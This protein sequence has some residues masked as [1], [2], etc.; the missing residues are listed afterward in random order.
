MIIGILSGILFVSGNYVFELRNEKKAK[1]EIKVLKLALQ[2]YKIKAE[3]FQV[4]KVAIMW[5]EEI[6]SKSYR[7][8]E[9]KENF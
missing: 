9:S 3:L 2:F 8:Y 6:Y 4:R 7:L 1:S 5:R